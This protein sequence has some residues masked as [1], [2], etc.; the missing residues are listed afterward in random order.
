MAQSP[1][2]IGKKAAETTTAVNTLVGVRRSD[3]VKSLG[4]LVKTAAK[5]PKPFAKHLGQYGKELVE[6][7]KGN[8]E[9][10]PDRRDRRFKDETWHKNPLYKRGLQSW[11]AMRHELKGLSLIHI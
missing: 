7:A 2:K 4:V 3:F 5:Q 1:D 11:L 6:I 8:S 10:E 9:L